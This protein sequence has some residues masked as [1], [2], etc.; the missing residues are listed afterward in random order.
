MHNEMITAKKK[1]EVWAI[2]R[3]LLPFLF[4]KEKLTIIFRRYHHMI[5]ATTT[6]TTTRSTFSVFFILQLYNNGIYSEFN[7]QV[8]RFINI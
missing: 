7:M 2:H 1:I 4:I 8:L 5:D 6:T 3:N